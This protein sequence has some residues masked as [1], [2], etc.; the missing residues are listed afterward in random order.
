MSTSLGMSLARLEAK[1]VFQ[2]LFARFPEL[3]CAEETLEWDKNPMFRGLI[4]LHVGTSAADLGD[5]TPSAET[6]ATV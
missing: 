4:Q 6:V 3:T 5:S 2:K 1:I